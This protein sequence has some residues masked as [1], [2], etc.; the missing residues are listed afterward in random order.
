MPEEKVTQES[1]IYILRE[2]YVLL[3]EKDELL[4][5]DINKLEERICRAEKD[6]NGV[7]RKLSEDID[8]MHLELK[9]DILKKS[10]KTN[11]KLWEWLK[12]AGSLIV[13]LLAGHYGLKG[14]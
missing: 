3:K 6:I 1:E 14:K 9:D 4:F 12:L 13:G 2:Q 8:A 10:E 11:T 7:R 5:R